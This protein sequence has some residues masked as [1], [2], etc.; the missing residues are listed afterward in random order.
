M[1]SREAARKKY[2]DSGQSAW[3]PILTLPL[4]SCVSF[5]KLLN[6]SML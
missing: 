6:L 5:G 4:S 2:V 1:I 3:V